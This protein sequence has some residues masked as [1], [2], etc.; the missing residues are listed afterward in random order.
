MNKILSIRDLCKAEKENKTYCSIQFIEGQGVI[1][2][3]HGDS[4]IILDFMCNAIAWVLCE[5]KLT[6][7]E[8]AIPVNDVLGDIRATILDMYKKHIGDYQ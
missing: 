1:N 6:V 2:Y 7:G 4:G 3:T 8:N 5:S